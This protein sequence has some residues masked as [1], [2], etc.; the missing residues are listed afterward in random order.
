MYNENY[1]TLI[2]EIKEHTNGNIACVHGSKVNI[3]QLSILPKAIYRIN[4]IPIKISMAFFI[5]TGKIILK[6]VWNYKRP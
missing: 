2:K 1:K 3:V 5:E 4:T 6:F